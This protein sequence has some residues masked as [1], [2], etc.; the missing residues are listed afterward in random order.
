MPIHDRYARITPYELT[1][2][3][4]DE[5]NAVLDRLT[6]AD[7]MPDSDFNAFIGSDTTNDAIR[8]LAGESVGPAES[9]HAAALLFHAVH[10]RAGACFLALLS[11]EEARQLVSPEVEG[12]Q[13]SESQRFGAEGL[14]PAS[15]YLQLPRHLF[16]VAPEAIEGG[17][18]IPESL[19]GMFWIADDQSVQLLVALGVRDARAGISVI[20]LPAIPSE[21]ISELLVGSIRPDGNDFSSSLPGAELENLYE[22][23]TAGEL[24]KL[25]GRAMVSLLSG[26]GGVPRAVPNLTPSQ[27]GDFRFEGGPEEADPGVLPSGFPFV[28]I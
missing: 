15:G 14:L 24:V 8:E 13:E 26:N 9:A 16:W 23:R 1:F 3:S 25:F 2:A 12:V 17:A 21:S 22:I 7:G 27:S 18:G 6:T 10:F 19:D 5:A 11:T 28:R 20:P 4:P